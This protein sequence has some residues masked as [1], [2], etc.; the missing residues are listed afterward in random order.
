[1][2]GSKGWGTKGCLSVL[3]LAAFLFGA[4]HTAMGAVLEAAPQ[5][6]TVRKRRV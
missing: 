4:I 5:C 2:H 3:S 6:P 1:M